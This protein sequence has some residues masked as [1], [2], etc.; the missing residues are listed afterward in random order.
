M[1]AKEEFIV[2]ENKQVEQRWVFE[3]RVDE[4]D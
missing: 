3:D 2:E 4:K 1:L